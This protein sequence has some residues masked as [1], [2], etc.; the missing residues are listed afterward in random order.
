MKYLQMLLFFV[1]LSG[2]QSMLLAQDSD[3][4]YFKFKVNSK[5]E[6]DIFS[7]IISIDN[8][9]GTWVY[10]YANPK[11]W[12][13]FTAH[14]IPY[15]LIEPS[16][17]SKL[18]SM[19]STLD[20]MSAWDCYPTYEVYEALMLQFAA[21]YPTICMLEEIGSLSS[22]RKL[23]ALKIT[24]KV[25]DVDFA[26]PQLFLSSSMH[27]DEIGGYSV[28]LQLADYLLSNYNKTGYDDVTKLVNKA[29]LWINPLANPDGTY[30]G[31]NETVLGA[32]RYNANL[33]DINRNFPDPDAGEHPDG[34][35]WQA[36]TE[37]MMAFA[38]K[39]H[40]N[41]AIN[42]HSG[43]EV[44]NYPWDTWSRPAADD[45]WWAYVGGNY[46]D[47]AQANSPDGYLTD[48]NNGLSNGYDWYRITGGRQDY[49]NYFKN[50]REFTLEI[51]ATKLYPSEQLV[52]LFSYNR[53]ALL[54]YLNEGLNGVQGMVKNALGQ[55]LM[56]K[57]EVLNHDTD[58]SEVYSN[59]Q[60]GFFARYLKAGTY[61]L[62]ISADGYA[63]YFMENV[64]VHDGQAHFFD[65]TMDAPSSKLCINTTT[66]YLSLA[67]GDSTSLNL[68]LYNCGNY[69][70]W[71]TLAVD[72]AANHSW[73]SI[74]KDSGEVAPGS[75]DSILFTL[76]TK[77]LSVGIYQA[78]LFIQADTTYAIAVQFDVKPQQ[79]LRASKSNFSFRLAQQTLCKD[80]LW[81]FN[82]MQT[83]QPFTLNKNAMWLHLNP[84]QGIIPANDSVA[85][86]IEVSADLPVGGYAAPLLLQG[87]YNLQWPVNLRVDTIPLPN[88]SVDSLNIR[89]I[90][91]Q[92]LADSFYLKNMG[93]GLLTVAL[94]IPES[95]ATIL[96]VNTTWASIDA[97][98]EACFVFQVNAEAL[99][100]GNYVFLVPCT[101]NQMVSL[102]P[103]NVQV[104]APPELFISA[105]SR[106]QTVYKNQRLYDSLLVFNTGGSPLDY[107]VNFV[108][109]D[110]M[111]WVY[112][113]TGNGKID[114]ADSVYLK[115]IWDAHN[116]DSGIYK[117]TL[118]IN[119]LIL[120]FEMQVQQAPMLAVNKNA[121]SIQLAGA[122]VSD[123]LIF[124]N[125][126]GSSLNYT[127]NWASANTA[128]FIQVNKTEGHLLPGTSDEIIVSVN[129]DFLEDYRYNNRLIIRWENATLGIPVQ[130]LNP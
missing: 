71:Y 122:P 114:A 61:T 103:I 76:R 3:L 84:D 79:A 126:G 55:P 88:F 50:C 5:T 13:A 9:D 59:T 74:N 119:H 93:G 118:E 67:M 53:A 100:P 113:Q 123:T 58:N 73:I 12:D 107:S 124:K 92:Q 45:A 120:P 101:M 30:K 127:L 77:D 125:T 8:F 99:E 10:A 65:V 21:Q 28:L 25:T 69:N 111:H 90:A 78:Q 89:L 23:L 105:E 95:D 91:G 26:K 15:S 46:R 68:P 82:S 27:G 97:K 40:F 2:S 18:L 33:I 32:S 66:R 42:I 83:A 116:L 20:E 94:Q 35:A 38:D 121:L 75:A 24:D 54:G 56:A 81:L 98:Q 22:G 112:V 62:K 11:E 60:N 52:S 31:G 117:G 36:E 34:N 63:D 87:N 85:V 47:S 44:V 102:F 29:Q 6:V 70:L 17:V 48:V 4:R 108:S 57:V 49:M 72:D 129:T 19:A 80:T 1:L 14:K 104:D 16:K 64:V 37:L 109:S 96:S 41:L 130:V 7:S 39:H 115:F 43:S 51:A 110:S 86:A 106:T 128:Q